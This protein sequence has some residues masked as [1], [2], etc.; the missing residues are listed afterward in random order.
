MIENLAIKLLM[1]PA[2]IWAVAQGFRDVHYMHFSQVLGVGWLIA[3]IGYSFDEYMLVQSKSPAANVWRALLMDV[4][5][6]TLVVWASSAVL[7]GTRVTFVGALLTAVLLGI[8]EYLIH[9][10]LLSRMRAVNKVTEE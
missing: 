7:V 6:T 4:A 5:L 2:I 3:V 10:W 9:Y 1:C 8:G